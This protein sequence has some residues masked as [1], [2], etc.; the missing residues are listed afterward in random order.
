MFT[1][2]EAKTDQYSYLSKNLLLLKFLLKMAIKKLIY[3][4]FAYSAELIN[5]I[6]SAGN[7][8]LRKEKIGGKSTDSD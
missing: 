6:G 4:V 3:S 7:G 1:I 8:I 5:A 2:D